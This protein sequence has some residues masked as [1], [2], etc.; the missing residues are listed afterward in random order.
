MRQNCSALPPV[1]LSG[2]G[3]GGAAPRCLPYKIPIWET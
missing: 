2:E 1:P 3:L